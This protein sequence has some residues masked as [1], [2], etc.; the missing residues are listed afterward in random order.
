[1]LTGLESDAV[2]PWSAHE[3]AQAKDLH[4]APLL[5]L[6]LLAQLNDRHTGHVVPGCVRWV[7]LM[8]ASLLSD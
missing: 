5:E 4:T 6:P 8:K 3:I 2:Q 7:G 1:M